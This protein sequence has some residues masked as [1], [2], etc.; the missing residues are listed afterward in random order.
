M[1][2]EITP[3]KRFINL[4]QIDKRDIKQIFYYAIFSGLGCPYLAFRYSGNY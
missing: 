2:K 1:K 3:W 4:L